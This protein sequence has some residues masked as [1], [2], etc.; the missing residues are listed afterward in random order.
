MKVKVV[1]AKACSRNK[2]ILIQSLA[3]VIA[4]FL[5]GVF[6]FAIGHNPISVYMAMLE[7]CFGSAYR[8]RETIIK[9][10]PLLITGLGVGVAFKMKFWNIGAEGQVLM[11]AF[12]A[13]FVALNAS[14]LGGPVLIILMMIA[15]ILC[16]GLW[17]LIPG[18]FKARFNANESI[19]TLMMNYIALKWVVYLQYG[20]WK[21]PAGQGFP[22]VANFAEAAVLPE[23]FGVHI[24]W[25][26]ALILVV[27]IH[28]FMNYTK[29]GYEITVLGESENT[30]RYAGMNVKGI[31]LLAVFISGGI[32]GL[33][34]MIQAS[35]VSNTLNMNVASGVGYTAI[36]VAWLSGLSAPWMLVVA[37]L[38][39]VL[40]Q[41]ASY[42]QTAFNIPQSA[43]DIIQATILFCILGSQFFMQYKVILEG[44]K[45]GKKGGEAYGN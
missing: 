39:A 36:I 25:I 15:A 28:V 31:V 16:G 41:G 27:V 24:G 18:Y 34:G 22:K 43:A 23:V 29:K 5:T 19:V 20:P 42:I 40:T 38:F 1:K 11:G 35:A 13:S 9:A 4:L 10:V 6:I 2:K 30:A 17:G 14:H 21:D 33:T 7:G 26:F 32:A 12:G 45:K 3:I 8:I 44:K 37:F